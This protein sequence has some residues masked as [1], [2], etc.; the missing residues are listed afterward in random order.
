[1]IATTF[2]GCCG[3]R[4][5]ADIVPS[6]PVTTKG[7]S[8]SEMVQ[9]QIRDILAVHQMMNSGGQ[10]NTHNSS[11]IVLNKAQNDA[12]AEGLT[13]L[14]Y[15]VIKEFPNWNEH[16]QP[17]FLYFK[18]GGPKADLPDAVVKVKNEPPRKPPTASR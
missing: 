2:Y 17:L 12:Y 4:V 14:G 3:L 11:L 6:H 10:K 8:A 9:N 18:E 7:L 16:K 15:S 13:A 5:I 1:M